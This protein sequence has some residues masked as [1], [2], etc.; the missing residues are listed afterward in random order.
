MPEGQFLV[1]VPDK[2]WRSEVLKKSFLRVT[3]AGVMGDI[4]V[5]EWDEKYD[6]PQFIQ[7]WR[8]GYG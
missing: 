5:S 2:A 3:V 4:A 6:A 1:R 7:W 8:S